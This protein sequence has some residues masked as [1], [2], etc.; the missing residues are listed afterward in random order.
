VDN[1]GRH[2]RGHCHPRRGPH[3]YVGRR[4]S[5]SPFRPP[6]LHNKSLFQTICSGFLWARN[7]MSR[8][9]WLA[10]PAGGTG[11]FCP[12]W[13]HQSRQK[14]DIL[15]RLVAPTETKGEP[16]ILVGG[17][18]Q[19]KRA[20]LL[21]RLEP[22]TGTKSPPFVPVGA[23][24][25]DKRSLSPLLARLAVGSETYYSEPKGSRSK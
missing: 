19:D 6:L 16:F 9:Q 11:T 7:N 12:G 21:S 17:S 23:S 8:I 3:T 13:R 2:Q 4:K 18:N 5:A 22:P 24:N 15:F 25:R 20:A 10:R 14:K 1:Q